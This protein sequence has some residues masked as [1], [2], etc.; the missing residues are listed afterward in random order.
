MLWA[1]T[2]Y[3]FSSTIDL[4]LIKLFHILFRAYVV[5]C[6]SDTISESGKTTRVLL[7]TCHGSSSHSTLP[8]TCFSGFGADIP[9][10]SFMLQPCVSEVPDC[11]SAMHWP[12]APIILVS[13]EGQACTSAGI[14]SLCYYCRCLPI[15]LF[16][17][18]V[19]LFCYVPSVLYQRVG[20]L[21]M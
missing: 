16:C 2:W 11:Q 4:G 13:S 20:R 9:A 21:S 12:A 18:G 8:E 5:V 17:F 7:S 6:D 10:H 19:C 14:I 3:K 1:S 15:S